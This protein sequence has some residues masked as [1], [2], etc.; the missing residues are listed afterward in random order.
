MDVEKVSEFDPQFTN[1]WFTDNFKNLSRINYSSYWCDTDSEENF[2]KNPKEGYTDKSIYYQFNS[3]GYRTK[4]FDFES[5]KPSI[6]CL[7]CSFTVGIGVNEFESWP[8][9]IQTSFTDY[10]VHNLGYAG[11]S[12]DTVARILS[13]IK[14]KLN[15]GIVFIAWPNK[16]RY[17]VYENT[18]VQSLHPQAKDYK[19]ISL[20]DCHYFNISEKNKFIVDCLSKLYG[21]QVISLN[22]DKVVVQGE[23]LGRDLHPGVEWHRYIADLFLK[24]FNDYTKI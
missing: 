5:P 23:S 20:E 22:A 7:G 2:R 24:Q 4:E 19:L 21:Y 10:N 14:N 8:A 15:T 3:Y 11:A 9:H 6:L 17:E 18:E 16:Y 12:C 1:Y 13:S